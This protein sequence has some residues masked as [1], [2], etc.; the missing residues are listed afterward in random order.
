MESWHTSHPPTNPQS[1]AGPGGGA[2][3]GGAGPGL[4]ADDLCPAG[5]T[6][7]PAGFDLCAE[8]GFDALRAG[9]CRAALSTGFCGAALSTGFC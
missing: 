4:G 7:C 6:G 2:T 1:R 8:F 3:A 9:F 5:D